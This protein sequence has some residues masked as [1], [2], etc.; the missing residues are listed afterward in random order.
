MARNDREPLNPWLTIPWEAYEGHMSSP[1]VRQ[2]QFLSEAFRGVLREYKPETV[3]VLGCSTGN[4]FEHIDPTLTRRVIGVDI[5]PDY[6]S[7][8]QGRHGSSLPNLD[9]ICADLSL[10]ELTSEAFDLIYCGLVFEYLDPERLI[11]K[12]E[13]W[14]KANGMFLV[15][16]Q[17]PS[18]KSGMITE[19][20]YKSLNR[21]ESI[22]NLVE[23]E[24]I[25]QT[26]F[27]VGLLEGKAYDQVL[28]SGKSFFVGHYRKK[29]D[30]QT[31]VSMRSW[32]GC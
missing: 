23:P 19:T 28:E 1:E 7:V 20:K 4:G 10:L 15:V 32:L 13:R 26:C 25:R 31:I 29:T 6:L 3:A 21:L 30:E 8:L 14:L 5:N 9:L 11:G 24:V 2:A 17:L 22:M 27:E 12:I 16:L 18:E